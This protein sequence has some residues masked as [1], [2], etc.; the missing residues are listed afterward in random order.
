MLNTLFK[1]LNTYLNLFKYLLKKIKTLQGLFVIE[2]IQYIKSQ[3]NGIHNN[4]Y[5][6]FI[7]C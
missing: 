5:C 7:G 6:F 4:M 3:E 2:F 1:L